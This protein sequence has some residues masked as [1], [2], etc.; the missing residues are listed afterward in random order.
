MNTLVFTVLLSGCVITDNYENLINNNY[1]SLKQQEYYY[2]GKSIEL[3]LNSR[4][5]SPNRSIALPN[6]NSIY[7]WSIDRSYNDKIKCDGN[8]HGEVSCSGL[9]HVAKS[10]EI[11]VFTNDD[12]IITKFKYSKDCGF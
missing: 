12:N 3:Y 9:G 1:E 11:S 6:N 7:V 4:D 10:C 2:T 8:L 5:R